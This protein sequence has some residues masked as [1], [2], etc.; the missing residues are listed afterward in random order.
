MSSILTQATYQGLSRPSKGATLTDRLTNLG[1]RAFDQVAPPFFELAR[2]SRIQSASLAFANAIS[3][4][5]SLPSTTA[6]TLLFTAGPRSVVP[7]FVG[8]YLVSGT[9]D[10]GAT[11]LVSALSGPITSSIPTANGTGWT[12]QVTRGGAYNAPAGLV[13]SAQTVPA[14]NLNW[15]PMASCQNGQ[16]TTPGTG[17][18]ARLD[19]LFV[20]PPGY[21]LAAA[22]LSGAGTSAKWGI[23]Y[24]WSEVDV[25]IDQ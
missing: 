1:S 21:G 12:T 11:L 8:C 22:V 13:V 18:V 23:S 6:T 10:L 15:I 9:A 19:G 5:Q 4:V 7:L 16:S 25:D 24:V 17:C 20:C 2:S 14:G 3:P